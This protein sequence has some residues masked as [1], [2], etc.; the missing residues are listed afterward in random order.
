MKKHNEVEVYILPEKYDEEYYK[1][2]DTILT[3]ILKPRTGTEEEN[4]INDKLWE[5]FQRGRNQ[6]NDRVGELKNDL[7]KKGKSLR[8]IRK[9]AE[10]IMVKLVLIKVEEE[11]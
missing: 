5:K 6:Y 9:H 11:R 10:K 3:A 8:S 2:V 1:A 7:G 4:K